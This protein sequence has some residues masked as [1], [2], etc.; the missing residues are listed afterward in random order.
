MAN[1]FN[2]KMSSKNQSITLKNTTVSQSRLDKLNDVQEED[3]AK[4]DGAILMYN[5]ST[6][7]YILSKDIFEQ[8]ENGN[9]I[10]QGGSF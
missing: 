5:A 9:F 10:M 4:V 1:G 3:A 6:D 2:V 8:D 7:T